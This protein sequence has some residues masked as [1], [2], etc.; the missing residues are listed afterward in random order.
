M[1]PRPS[2]ALK[3]VDA[4]PKISR[5]SAILGIVS[6]A[7]FAVLII[8][9]FILG[10]GRIGLTAYGERVY[11]IWHSES[12]ATALDFG[13]MSTLMG[14]CIFGA[15]IAGILGLI[16]LFLSGGKQKAI[17]GVLTGFGLIA[18]LILPAI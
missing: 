15:F 1:T 17:T 3:K 8:G 16:G 7:V 5:V 18:F 11:Q 9:R 2:A 13:N 6:D 12:I 4:D 14:L 10:T